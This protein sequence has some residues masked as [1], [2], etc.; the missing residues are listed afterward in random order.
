MEAFVIGCLSLPP[1]S[2]SSFAGNAVGD[3]AKWTEDLAKSA[4]PQEVKK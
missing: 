3:G 1:S 2:R 4:L